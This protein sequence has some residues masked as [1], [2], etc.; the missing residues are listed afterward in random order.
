[1]QGVACLVGDMSAQCVGLLK[2]FGEFL[3]RVVYKITQKYQ[4]VPQTVN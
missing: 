1:M 3:S 4:N 2:S